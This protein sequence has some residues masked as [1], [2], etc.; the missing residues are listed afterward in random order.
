M[1]LSNDYESLKMT[2]GAERQDLNEIINSLNIELASYREEL[3]RVKMDYR[4]W[5][6]EKENFLNQNKLYE[7]RISDLQLEVIKLKQAHAEKDDE[8]NVTARLTPKVPAGIK[9]QSSPLIEP[10]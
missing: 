10:K 2:Y 6:A 1:N 3:T 7:N 9:S 8:R 4:S 5:Q